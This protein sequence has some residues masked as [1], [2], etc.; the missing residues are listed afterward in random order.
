MINIVFIL[1]IAGAAVGVYSALGRILE[2]YRRRQKAKRDWEE[3]N[4][5]KDL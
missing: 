5:N 2:D 1:I 4:R 3:F